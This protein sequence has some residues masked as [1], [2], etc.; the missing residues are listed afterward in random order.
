MDS[1]LDYL[2]EQCAA[3]VE[4]TLGAQIDKAESTVS[5]WLSGPD[6]YLDRHRLLPPSSPPT[7]IGT[8]RKSHSVI[9][10]DRF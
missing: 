3:R 8:D 9:C 2:L 5:S 1:E 7:T 4:E 10:L 6:Q